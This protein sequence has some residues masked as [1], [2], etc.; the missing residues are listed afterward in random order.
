M[1][2]EYRT[3]HRHRNVITIN[4]LCSAGNSP[5]RHEGVSTTKAISKDSTVYGE[6]CKAEPRPRRGRRSEACSQ[7]HAPLG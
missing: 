4:T 6:L 3:L 1:I 2:N 7:G 5:I